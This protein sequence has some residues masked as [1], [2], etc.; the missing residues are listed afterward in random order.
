[1]KQL[2]LYRRVQMNKLQYLGLIIAITP[3]THLIF[4]EVGII[5]KNASWAELA[6]FFSVMFFTGVFLWV[7]G[8]FYKD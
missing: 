8:K 7:V 3:L 5:Q 2:S 1:M 4:R 6:V